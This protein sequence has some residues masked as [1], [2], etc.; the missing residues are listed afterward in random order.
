[1]K[2]WCLGNADASERL[3]EYYHTIYCLV[4]EEIQTVSKCVAVF[5]LNLVNFKL[6][7]IHF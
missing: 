4:E 5:V 1:M 6:S 2:S 3:C 7:C